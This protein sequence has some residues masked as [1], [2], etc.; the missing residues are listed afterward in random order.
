MT[1]TTID[2]LFIT[3]MIGLYH[4]LEAIVIN[5]LRKKP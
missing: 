1:L 2:I 5:R 4:I 3:F